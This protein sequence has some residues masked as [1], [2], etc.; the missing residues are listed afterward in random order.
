MVLLTNL[1][2]PSV[3]RALLD[4]PENVATLIR[5][6]ISRLLNLILDHTFPSSTNDSVSAFASS[7]MKTATSSS[8]RN[9]SKEVLNCLRILQRV[10]PVVFEVEGES[11]AFELEVLWKKPESEDGAG[12]HP[13]SSEIPHFVIDDDEDSEAEGDVTKPAST[14]KH[15]KELPALGEK[16]LRAIID[17]LF[18]C[19]FT[20]P[21]KIQV[22]HYKI[23]YIIWCVVREIRMYNLLKVSK[24][25]RCW[26]YSRSRS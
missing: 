26:F 5:V 21:K 8:D 23:N 20:L 7:F 18:C 16:L 3:R 6:V 2:K 1:T 10:L 14:T 9:T 11:N 24:G 19:G 22:D 13:Q 25:E 17:L 4:A 12:D 15:T